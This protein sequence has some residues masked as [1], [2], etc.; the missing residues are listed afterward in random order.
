MCV[1]NG[2]AMLQARSRH[3]TAAQVKITYLAHERVP[4]LNTSFFNEVILYHEPSKVLLTTDFFWCG[5]CFKLALSCMLRVA[6]ALATPGAVA[7]RGRGRAA[8]GAC[9]LQSRC[10][11]A[12]VVVWPRLRAHCQN[13]ACDLTA[14]STHRNFPKDVPGG[15][16]L[17][18]FAMDR[19]YQPFYFNLMIK[20][21]SAQPARVLVILQASALACIARL[22]DV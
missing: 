15:T 1:T 10:M 7:A 14:G 19:I 4:V 12:T 9:A 17:F 13:C 5:P 11:H 16:K 2:S 18:K 21:K 20:D 22:G 8:G 6:H 3:R